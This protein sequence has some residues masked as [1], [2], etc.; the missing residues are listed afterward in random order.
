MLRSSLER[1]GS[2]S[3]K[4]FILQQNIEQLQS[5]LAENDPA[6]DN[7]WE[8]ITLADSLRTL[9]QLDSAMFGAHVTRGRFCEK[10]SGQMAIGSADARFFHRMVE[11]ASQPFLI[12]DPRPG[13]RIVDIN[14]AY[15]SA[16]MAARSS[17]A[18]EKL[19][20]AFPDNP[21][22]PTADGV[23]N[24][25]ASILTATECGIPHT[26]AIQRY[27]VR[28]DDGNFVVRYWRPRNTPIFDEG[29]N[30]LFVL[31]QA[32]DVTAQVARRTGYP[33]KN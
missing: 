3:I 5:V 10:T 19:F 8:R 20:D 23:S 29:G 2:W 4:R 6:A 24:L 13:L 32:E 12:L 26:M 17:V 21:D 18:G 7:H 27:D 1:A 25:Y 15:A 30:L 31:H 14:D 16:T 9:A 22:D 11:N 28:D 33:Y